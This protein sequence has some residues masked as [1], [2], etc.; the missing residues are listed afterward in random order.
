[1][2]T[3]KTLFSAVF[4][5][6]AL[7]LSS[8]SGDDGD[9]NGGGGSGF[10]LTAKVGGSNYKSYVEPQATT[11]GGMLHIQSSTSSGDA[12][13]IQVANYNGVGTYTSGNNNLMSG[14]INYMDMGAT[15]G[16]F[17]AYTSV[18]GTGTVEITA[19]DD[20][21]VTGTFTATVVKNE[22]GST[23]QVTIT[24]GKFRAK[25]N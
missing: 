7:L 5:S 9:N 8:C 24:N 25:L 3:L 15:P 23:E 13:Q 21:S 2:K 1:M 18:R 19:V 14:Y 6:A 17:T 16:Q 4:V 12:I 10:Y 11:A 20:S 22:E